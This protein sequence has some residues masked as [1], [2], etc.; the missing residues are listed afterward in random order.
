MALINTKTSSLGFSSSS[1]RQELRIP[2]SLED[3]DLLNH[4]S[5]LLP[6]S[7]SIG[8]HEC[9]FRACSFFTR[10]T[11]SYKDP[12]GRL[13]R[14]GYPR[15]DTFLYSLRELECMGEG[16][17][18]YFSKVVGDDSLRKARKEFSPR[19]AVD[20]IVVI[21]DGRCKGSGRGEADIPLPIDYPIER[22]LQETSIAESCQEGT[23]LYN[24]GFD[25]LQSPEDWALIEPDVTISPSAIVY[26]CDGSHF[27][28]RG[29]P[30]LRDGDYF[31]ELRELAQRQFEFL[32]FEEP[33]GLFVPAEGDL[34][35]YHTYSGGLTLDKTGRLSEKARREVIKLL[36]KTMKELYDNDIIYQQTVPTNMRYDLGNKIFLNHHNCMNIPE[37]S[38]DDVG[39]LL[40]THDY[41]GDGREFL[42]YYFG[43]GQETPY[44][45]DECREY[46][47][48]YMDNFLA[49]GE[50]ELLGMWKQ[51][52]NIGVQKLG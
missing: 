24:E 22:H 31:K 52:G 3:E 1:Y 36:A 46:L 20:G 42:R 25:F 32:R 29:L 10:L 6:S 16:D 41:I 34:L 15:E 17:D 13:Q 30:D 37:L 45:Q 23:I 39:N 43:E 27:V 33:I 35:L 40:Y 51:R 9:A 48:Q 50:G 14:V 49:G 11:L 18:A 26:D 38:D 19:S 47:I 12:W 2:L 5:C 7:S 44:H 28:E 8:S 4:C 21:E